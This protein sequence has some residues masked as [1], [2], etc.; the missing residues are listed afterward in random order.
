MKKFTLALLS[1]CLI[2]FT[3]CSK[4]EPE[5]LYTQILN[6]N[7]LIVGV[8]NDTPPFGFIDEKGNIQG[9]DIDLAKIIAKTIL[10]DDN[11]VEFVPV[12]P[13]NRIMMLN[14]RKVDMICATM[15]ITPKRQEIIDFSIPYYMAG[16]TFLVPKSSKVAATTDLRKK[17]II[18]V[19]GSTAE[20]NL[21]IILPDAKL[22]GFKTYK[23]GFTA[24][25]NDMA[26]AM[27]AD[28]TILFGL[29]NSNPDFKILTKRY[30]KEPY[31]IGFKKSANSETLKNEV[32]LILKNLI[33]T[34]EIE[35]LKKKWIY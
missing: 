4:S 35:K 25:K 32:D 27:A 18:V 29:I 5:D 23:A 8:K 15:S 22:V 2:F 17:R 7:K 9:F 13:A 19:F 10:G 33:S 11:K 3:A 34:G 20:K 16:Q 6:R 14:S 31:A 1:F 30:T 21:R 28:D 12:T 26:D 24:L